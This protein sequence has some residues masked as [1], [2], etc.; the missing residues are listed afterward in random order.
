M[1]LSIEDKVNRILTYYK[2]AFVV[3]VNT[4]IRV[5]SRVPNNSIEL[6]IIEGRFDYKQVLTYIQDHMDDHPIEYLILYRQIWKELEDYDEN[7]GED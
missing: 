3:C 6:L 5:L 1:G 7:H 4:K 2:Y